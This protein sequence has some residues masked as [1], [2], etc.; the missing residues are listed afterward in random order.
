MI[1][2]TVTFTALGGYSNGV[3]EPIAPGIGAWTTDAAH[4]NSPRSSF[5][6]AVTEGGANGRVYALGG[7]VGGAPSATVE[8][9][10]GT[11]WVNQ[12]SMTTPRE[13]LAAAVFGFRLYAIGGN[14][15]AG[16]PVATVERHT[17]P[18]AWELVAPLAQP[19]R[20]LGAAAAGN[21]MYAIGGEIVSGTPTVVGTVEAYDDSGTWSART[22]MP[23]PRRSLGVATAR[24]IVYAIGG[25]V[26]DG[27]P[28]ATVEA[29]DPAT[30]TWAA[31]TPMPTA[32]SGA[33]VVSNDQLIYVIGGTGPGGVV[34]ASTYV[35]DTASDTWTT[36]ADMATPRTGLGAAQLRTSFAGG[37]G[38]WAI[39]G[40]SASSTTLDVMEDF[41]ESLLYRAITSGIESAPATVSQSGVATALE[42]GDAVITASS[43]S[44]ECT[45]FPIQSCSFL[46]IITPPTDM[47]LDV[48][49]NNSVVSQPFAVGGWAINRSAATGPGVNAIHVYAFP[50]GGGNPIFL[51]VAQYGLARS[52]IGAIYGSQ[53]TGS[54]FTITVSTLPAGAYNINAYAHN[55][56]SGKFDTVRTA[57]VT[58]VTAVSNGLLAVDTPSSGATLTS[59]FE[60]GGWAIDRGASI[61]TG[62]DACSSSSSQPGRRRRCSSARPRTGSRA[63][64]SGRSSARDSPTPGI[65]SPSPDSGP[66]ASRCA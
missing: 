39:G 9:N 2:Q 24:N 35:Y 59:A 19:R 5:A 40:R 29:Y 45:I 30:D 14:T 38:V 43:G 51:G 47:A 53:F 6:T 12:A 21:A 60:V 16:T 55:A 66:A 41:H 37:K 42:F 31:K 15:T 57:T 58:V 52:D 7:V 63:V 61:G 25:Q 65:T 36:R 46:T 54:G 32:R 48:P 34:E 10:D 18:D 49:T 3:T 33:A 27:S 26:A 8:R 64:M 11:G 23:T 62:I 44:V 22:P 50:I 20:Y 1:G 28:V 56:A 17:F 4:L 13:G